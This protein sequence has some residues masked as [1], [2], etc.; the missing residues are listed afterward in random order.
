L[1]NRPLGGELAIKLLR[2]RV[3]PIFAVLEGKNE[4]R[5]EEHNPVPH[6]QNLRP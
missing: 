3:V 2:P 4:A 5:V 1:E 6:D